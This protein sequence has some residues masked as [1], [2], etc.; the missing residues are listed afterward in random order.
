MARPKL[1]TALCDT[2]NIE[3][4]ILLAGMGSRGKAT[5]PELVAAVSE[6]G[7]MGVIGGSSLPPEVLR[8][9]IREVRRLTDKPIGVDLLLPASLAEDAGT[10]RTE[11]RA[12]LR[13][14]FPE[15]IAFVQ[16]LMAQHGLP[17]VFVAD[18]AVVSARFIESQVSVVL[19]ENVQV[20]AAGLGDPSWVAPLAHEK[21]MVVMGLAGAPRHAERQVAAGVD[22]IVAQGYEAGGHTG[23]IANF[24]LL[25]QV[26]D[27]VHPQAVIA[28]GGIGDGRGIAAAFSLGAVGVWVGTAFL[29]SDESAIPGPHKEQIIKGRSQD[30]EVQRFYSGKTMRALK[31][32][33]IA[34]W[35]ASNLEP[36]PMPY[37]RVLMDDFN[38]AAARAE[39]FE[40][41][42]N[43]AGQIGG[44]V[45][46]RKPAA[47]IMEELVT[48]AVETL[49]GLRDNSR[50]LIG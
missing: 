32:E 31:N 40:L 50:V 47:K 36:L 29:V 39:R 1:R 27:T 26:V 10:T 33:I 38:E 2:L 9:V 16:K 17:E 43:P 35:Q 8:G 48:G 21:G 4:P 25:P 46:E 19:E 28:A 3:Y 5:P 22:I 14:R 11:V 45:R 23:K 44:L 15:H 12:Q 18:E 20:F 13:E 42:S 41:V 34:A 30:F 7:G 49:A 24:P 37:Q 6:A